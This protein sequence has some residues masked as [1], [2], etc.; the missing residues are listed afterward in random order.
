MKDCWS[1][2]KE[3]ISR[4]IVQI[5]N[6]QIILVFIFITI[7]KNKFIVLA[8]DSTENNLLISLRKN[9]LL[10]ILMGVGKVFTPI[11]KF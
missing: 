3:I 7:I 2:K 4:L 11:K 5:V 6:E 9:W 8:R 1:K 10:Q